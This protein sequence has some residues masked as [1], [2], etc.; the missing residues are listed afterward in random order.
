MYDLTYQELKEMMMELLATVWVWARGLGRK[1]ETLGQFSIV[2][3][4]TKA[5]ILSQNMT[6][7]LP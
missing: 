6:F 3:V 1:K 5:G 7:S 4:A 2:F